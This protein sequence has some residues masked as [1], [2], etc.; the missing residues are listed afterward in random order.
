MN[1]VF[2]KIE[3]RKLESFEKTLCNYQSYKIPDIKDF[4][5]LWKSYTALF[6]FGKDLSGKAYYKLYKKYANPNKS[7][8]A[9]RLR[10]YLQYSKKVSWFLMRNTISV[11]HYTTLV[12]KFQSLQNELKAVLINQLEEAGYKDFYQ[13]Y[14]FYL[15]NT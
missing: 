7:A 12:N 10:M 5:K 13:K 11:E 8:Y 9:E 6:K 3:L 2:Y 4:Y 14:K 15:E 1:D